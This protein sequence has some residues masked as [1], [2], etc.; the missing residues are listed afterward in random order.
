MSRPDGAHTHGSGGDAR[1]LGLLAAAVVIFGSAGAAIVAFITE[2]L[3]VLGAMVG[4]TLAAVVF[5]AVRAWRKGWRPRLVLAWQP[6]AALPGRQATPIAAQTVQALPA[7]Q[8]FH[9][10]YH[11]VTA[12]QVA[13]VAEQQRRAIDEG[14]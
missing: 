14:R 13:E 5:F 11:G 6:H 1:G 12:E 9:V 10:H 3:E 8:H 7:P 2:V 4:L